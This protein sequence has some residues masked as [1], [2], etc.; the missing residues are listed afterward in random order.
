[1]LLISSWRV[2]QGSK[3][4]PLPWSWSDIL[5]VI[6]PYRFSHDDV[7]YP[8]GCTLSHMHR[9]WVDCYIYIYIKYYIFNILTNWTRMAFSMEGALESLPSW[10]SWAP[11]FEVI[12]Y[13]GGL[14]NLPS[15]ALK[16]SPPRI[17]RQWPTFRWNDIGTVQKT[18][19]GSSY[20]IHLVM[21]NIA[22][23]NHHFFSLR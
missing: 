20:W 15:E 1:M 19:E 9:V 21:T 6:W 16:T 23:E 2:T 13:R 10:K 8:K 3:G 17:W 11:R 18:M 22:M 12:I 4:G 14:S 7:N 5:I